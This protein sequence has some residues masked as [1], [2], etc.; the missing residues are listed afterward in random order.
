MINWTR[1]LSPAL[2]RRV[3]KLLGRETYLRLA[4]ESYKKHFLNT[5]KYRSVHLKYHTGRDDRRENP[6]A[7]FE[8]YNDL[9]TKPTQATIDEAKKHFLELTENADTESNKVR[10]L[11]EWVV[12]K[13]H[14]QYD[15]ERWGSNEYWSSPY[16]LWAQ[17]QEYGYFIDDCDGWAALLYWAMRLIGV[18][19]YRVYVRAGMARQRNGQMF[20]H[21]N[22]L[23]FP[24]FQAPAYIEGSFYPQEN[25]REWLEFGVNNERY[26]GTWFLFNEYEVM[27]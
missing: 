16:D 7:I 3:D 4:E 13:A 9:K 25:H 21:A 11:A 6:S 27:R 22:I 8:T 1:W 5:R 23:Y 2:L 14:Y 20:G 26:P 19:A 18:P 17:Y 24:V 15:S 10:I 12:E